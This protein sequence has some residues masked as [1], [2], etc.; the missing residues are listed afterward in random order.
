MTGFNEAPAEKQGKTRGADVEARLKAIASMRPP[1][2]S[3]GKQ[4]SQTRPTA[5]PKAFNEA[6]AEK[7]GKL[8]R[9]CQMAGQPGSLQ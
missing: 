6:P 7:Q 3:R 1:P 9:H 8:G 2:K 4:S 5:T